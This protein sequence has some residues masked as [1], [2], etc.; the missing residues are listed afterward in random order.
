MLLSSTG[1]WS[2]RS[3]VYTVSPGRRPER[4]YTLPGSTACTM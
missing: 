3:S 4:A 1:G 2:G